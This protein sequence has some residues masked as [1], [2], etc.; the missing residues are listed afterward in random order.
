M[1]RPMRHA[2]TSRSWTALSLV[3]LS[4]VL[5]TGLPSHHHREQADVSDDAETRLVAGDHHD[6]GTRL[7]EQDDR[8]PVGG[9]QMAAAV[10]RSVVFVESPFV[11]IPRAGVEVVRP[12]ER[13]PPPVAPRAPP[14]RL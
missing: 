5:S 8:V 4:G 14:L 6:H 1:I 11:S 12:K 9:P 2:R 10:E 3:I 13:P 7:V